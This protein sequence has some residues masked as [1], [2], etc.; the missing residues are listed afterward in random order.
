MLLQVDMLRPGL[1]G[2]TREAFSARYCGRR[3]V[4][5]AHKPDQRRWDNGGLSHAHEL[6]ALL[7]QVG[8]Q[9]TR[10]C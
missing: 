2:S 9:P 7:S 10:L 6:H 8:A 4:P 1:L 3:L 5:V